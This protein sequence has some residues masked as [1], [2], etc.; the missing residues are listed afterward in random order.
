MSKMA[1]KVDANPIMIKWAR[2]NA[3]F[4]LEELPDYLK[5]A[6]KWETGQDKPTWTDLRNMAKKYKRPSFFYFLSEPPKED[7]D[8]IEFRSDDRMEDYSPALRLELRKAKS[9]RD[10]YIKIHEDMGMK[11]PNF[12]QYVSNEQNYIK[13]G[14]YIR[15][16][17]NVSF[18]T[19]K[20]WILN[21]NGNRD[22]THN[23]FLN[24]W[25]EILFDMGILVFETKDVL[26]SE[27][28][29]CSLYYDTCPIILFRKESAIC[30]VDKYNRKET[31]CNKVAAEILIPKET[32]KDL[33]L[34]TKDKH[35]L[36]VAN[37]SNFYGVSKQSIVYKLYDSRLISNELKNEWINQ[38][39]QYNQ[40]KRKKD[41]EKRKK[42]EPRIPIT[43]RKRKQDGTPFTKLVLDA[44]ENNV[45]TATQAMRYLDTSLDN[46]NK[47]DLNING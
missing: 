34:F 6:E 26:E 33:D 46:I 38:H 24:H 3:G 8:L 36:K 44:Y 12:S 31:F 32:L 27:I 21:S 5:D 10:A 23:S 4:T 40:Q 11:I 39:E 16:L 15:N 19:Q 22:S 13:L 18:E 20:N 42:S 17:L 9:R 2:E 14:Q 1:V 29:G 37:L 28:S 47:L 7:D 43:T 41:L 35:I 25:K 30:D 45:I